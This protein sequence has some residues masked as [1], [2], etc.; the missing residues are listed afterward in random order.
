MRRAQFFTTVCAAQ[1][2]TVTSRTS[3]GSMSVPR[4][5]EPVLLPSPLITTAVLPSLKPTD[6]P[7]GVALV[8]PMES[9]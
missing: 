4:L 2:S 3:V 5:R 7:M 6:E 9:L 1:I 8:P